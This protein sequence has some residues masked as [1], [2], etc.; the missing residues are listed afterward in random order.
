MFIIYR[1]I[2]IWIRVD[3]IPETLETT[4]QSAE[5]EKKKK[6]KNNFEFYKQ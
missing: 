2:M 6:K 1:G 3:F 4:R 5:R